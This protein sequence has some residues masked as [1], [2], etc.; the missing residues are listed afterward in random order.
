M[1]SSA[2]VNA[3]LLAVPAAM[4]AGALGFQY[5]GGLPPCEMCIWQ[6][7]ALVA[8]I[9]IAAAAWAAGRSRLVLVLAAVALLGDAAL[10]LFHAG[11][12]QKWWEGLTT[13]TAS[14]VT[15]STADMLT[16]VIAQPLVRCDAIAWSLFGISMAGWNAIIAAATG[17]WALWMLRRA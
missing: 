13:C 7:W 9:A 16:Q 5:I 6:R 14:A 12:E 11:V 15:G 2:A 3:A 10:G 4:L 17:V 8:V 1:R